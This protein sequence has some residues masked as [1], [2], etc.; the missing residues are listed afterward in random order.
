MR[1]EYDYIDT[2]HGPPT[3]YDVTVE[4]DAEAR[5][6][7]GAILSRM[8]D[9]GELRTLDLDRAMAKRPT[10]KRRLR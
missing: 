4:T 7:L 3:N 10:Y 6:V 5:V 9:S 8:L 2:K 1:I